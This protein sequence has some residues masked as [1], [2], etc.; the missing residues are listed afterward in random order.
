MKTFN[1]LSPRQHAMLAALIAGKPLGPRTSA[2]TNVLRHLERAGMIA[3]TGSEY[4]VKLDV[5]ER[6]EKW[7]REQA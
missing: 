6:W 4:H 1:F 7:Q 3:W 5:V 2:R